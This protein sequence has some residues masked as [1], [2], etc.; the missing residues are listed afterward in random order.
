L[1]WQ[2]AIGG[3]Q[4]AFANPEGWAG[5]AI[6][7]ALG[8]YDPVRFH[9]RLFE[10]GDFA[11][12]GAHF[13]VLI[14]GTTDHQV[15]SWELAEQLIVAD[16]ARSNLLAAAPASSGSINP[17]PF[18]DIPAI[19]YNGLPVELRAAIGGPLGDV[20][21]P[22]P[23]ATGGQA[24]ILAL[25]PSSAA[26][27]PVVATQEFVINFDQIIPKP[28]CASS[29]SDLILVQGPVTL[30]Q[31]VIFT[32]SG[33]FISQFHAVGHLEVTPLDATTG[34]PAGETYRARVNEH[35][36]GIV[37]DAVTLASS[38]QMFVEIPPSGPFRGRL[39]VQLQVGPGRSNQ[40]SIAVDCLP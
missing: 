15:I 28:F 21:S 35:H 24:T 25:Q 2:D 3:V 9:V 39:K 13:E 34:Q 27:G 38:F 29:L 6:Q 1:T 37:T 20:S 5:S 12:G 14:P 19:I 33:N 11:L 17:S 23:I 26:A 22:V 31:Q 40:S 32:R 4:T 7:L 30:R 10:V 16:F 18:K 8:P 36:K